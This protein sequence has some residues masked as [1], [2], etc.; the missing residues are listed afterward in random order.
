VLGTY[1]RRLIDLAEQFDIINID[2]ELKKFPDL[3][4]GFE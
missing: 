3:A 2:K 1:S 4:A